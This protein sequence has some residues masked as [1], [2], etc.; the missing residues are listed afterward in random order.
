VRRGDLVKEIVSYGKV[1]QGR[2]NE[3]V[4]VAL[5]QDLVWSPGPDRI[6]LSDKEANRILGSESQTLNTS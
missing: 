5:E 2:A 4:K 3:I 6:K 1:D